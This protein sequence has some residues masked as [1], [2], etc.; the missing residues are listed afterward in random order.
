MR[1]D[2]HEELSLMLQIEAQTTRT[3]IKI[4]QDRMATKIEATR[5]ELALLWL[6]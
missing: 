3:E 2:L 1:N 6:I 5:R 4:T